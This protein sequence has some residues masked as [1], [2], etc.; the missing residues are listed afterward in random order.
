MRQERAWRNQTQLEPYLDGALEHSVYHFTTGVR[1]LSAMVVGLFGAIDDPILDRSID[2][3][4]EAPT[5]SSLRAIERISPSAA[6]FYRSAQHHCDDP[7]SPAS[8]AMLSHALRELDGTIRDVWWDLSCFVDEEARRAREFGRRKPQGRDAPYRQQVQIISRPFGL[9]PTDE[10][11]WLKCEQFH[12][13][14]H[15][16]H[17]GVSRRLS[18]EQLA[19]CKDA[20]DLFSRVAIVCEAT[21]GDAV[22]RAAALLENVAASEATTVLTKNFPITHLCASGS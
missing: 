2:E 19:F 17:I 22:L 21:Y 16:S 13:W 12:G 15:R 5:T 8:A 6:D 9:S 7:D 18:S 11:T 3:Q 10:Q 1:S 4:D 14:A 20:L